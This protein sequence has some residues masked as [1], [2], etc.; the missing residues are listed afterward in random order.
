MKMICINKIKG[1]SVSLCLLTASLLGI[2]LT[3]C[4]D[5]L[6]Q[7]QSNENADFPDDSYSVSIAIAG[8]GVEQTRA[9]GED[10]EDTEGSLGSEDESFIDIDDLYVMTFSI[11]D[12]KKVLTSDSKLLEV[13]WN[14]SEK[15]KDNSSEIFYNGETAFLRTTLNSKIT[16]YKDTISPATEKNFCIVA[17]ANISQFTK[18]DNQKFELSFDTSK[19]MTF[20]ELQDA[21]VY[22]FP[23]NTQYMEKWK[24]MPFS[25]K[26]GIKTKKG[27]PLFGVKRVNLNHYDP[28]IH[29]FANPYSLSANGNP[30]LWMLRAFS[31]VEVSLSDALIEKS[32]DLGGISIVSA[33][34]DNEY[35]PY[36][37]VIPELDRMSGY[38]SVIINGNKTDGTGGTGQVDKVPNT[39]YL[40]TKSIDNEPLYFH[41]NKDT[42]TSAIIYLPEFYLKT[43][44]KSIIKLILNVGEE[45]QDFEFEIKPYKNQDATFTSDDLY[46]WKFLIRNHIYTFSIDVGFKTILSVI[47]DDWTNVYENEFTFGEKPTTE[48][49]Q[50][51]EE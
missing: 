39:D 9:A 5:D 16:E 4:V 48:E 37:W 22:N 29:S 50:E 8:M 28:S 20:G 19:G 26:D 13:L 21:L 45:K 2:G 35:A 23:P 11:P 12:G 49:E 10:S 34:V 1:F 25:E 17:I 36:F 14:G 18:K 47:S 41:V 43:Q 46:Y 32:L 7:R 42:K 40:P 15:G 30:T 44:A 27:I 51:N 31:K 6:L 3:G 33:C 24:W 38:N